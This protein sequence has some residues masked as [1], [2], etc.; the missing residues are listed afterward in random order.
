MHW[1]VTVGSASPE[2]VPSRLR[3]WC[4]PPHLG[5]VTVTA[6]RG[7]RLP[8]WGLT[9]APPAWPRT[10]P[11]PAWLAAR[12]PPPGA[13][14]EPPRPAY[15][16]PAGGAA[17]CSDLHAGSA[18]YG[19]LLTSIGL[20]AV[21]GSLGLA[22]FADPRH[23]PALFAY[24]IVFSGVALSILGATTSAGY[25]LVFGFLVGSSQ[26]MFMSM[27]LAIIQSSV[28]DEFRGRATSFYQMITLTPMALFG[29]GMGG[30]ADVTEPRP[31]M[32]AL[33]I[34]FIVAMGIYALSS[35]WLRGLF[36]PMGWLP[37]PA[38]AESVV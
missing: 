26:A 21:I 32:I 4:L 36:R 8:L 22:Q 30:L 15:Q 31:L 13:A 7:A 25:A 6:P 11:P 10:A 2:P 12:P 28:G 9:D 14:A 1:A 38:T 17:A 29:W 34:A 3:M 18:M 19:A 5:Q 23:R 24:A 33:G 16:G 27:T 35:S 37:V 20:G